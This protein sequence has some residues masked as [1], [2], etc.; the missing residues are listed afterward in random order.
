LATV[1]SLVEQNGGGVG[2]YGLAASAQAQIPTL[3][4]G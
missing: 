4:V 1:L 2:R 3:G